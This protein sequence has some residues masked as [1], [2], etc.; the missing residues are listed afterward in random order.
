[1]QTFLIVYAI[2]SILT[3]VASAI[4]CKVARYRSKRVT[5][6]EFLALCLMS[7]IPVVNIIV[8]FVSLLVIISSFD[9]MNRELF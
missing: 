6:G 4:A 7:V 5:I 3:L 8:I 9:I 1:M 2:F